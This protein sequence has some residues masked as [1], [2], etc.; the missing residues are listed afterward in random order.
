MCIN[1]QSLVEVILNLFQD[2]LRLHLLYLIQC[3][4]ELVSGPS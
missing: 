2:P 1:F 3:H 4:P